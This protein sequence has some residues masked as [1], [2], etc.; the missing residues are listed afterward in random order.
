VSI[1]ERLKQ[2]REETGLN[3]TQFAT[4]I[5]VPRTTLIGW[6]KGKS[7]SIET[8][9]KLKERFNINLDWLLTGEG[10]MFNDY[11]INFSTNNLAEQK[12]QLNKKITNLTSNE[13]LSPEGSNNEFN[14]AYLAY[15]KDIEVVTFRKNVSMPIKTAPNDPS[16][17]V[18]LPLYNQRASAGSGQ[19]DSQLPETEALVPVL[20]D[21]L[22]CRD[23]KYCGVFKVA[24]DTLSDLNLFKGD[25]AL[26]DKSDSQGDGIFLI[27]LFGDFRIKNSNNFRK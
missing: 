13:L 27:S 23:P 18:M 5:D 24:S 9:S 2:I 12:P 3:T 11:S 4:E 19:M 14:K 21:I 6:E 16:G 26:F 25:W 20:Y 17:L 15:H 7:V 22:D 10:A 8:I 1:N